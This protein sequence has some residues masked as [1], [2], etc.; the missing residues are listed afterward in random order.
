M[1]RNRWNLKMILKCVRE[2]TGDKEKLYTKRKSW[3]K[4]VNIRAC[5]LEKVT[6]APWWSQGQCRQGLWLILVG[7]VKEDEEN[8]F[9]HPKMLKHYPILLSF[10]W[11][12]AFMVTIHMK[13]QICQLLQK[14]QEASLKCFLT[15]NSSLHSQS[16]LYRMNFN[17]YLF[18][19]RSPWLL[20]FYCA[21]PL[22]SFSCSFHSTALWIL[23]LL[24]ES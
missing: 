14:T 20:Q 18:F 24:A 23:I 19:F 1:K 21:L 9:F 5:T 17:K 6:K 16:S 7:H 3:H 10:S 2:C 12:T 13:G 15:G 4:S 8:A 22:F 11:E